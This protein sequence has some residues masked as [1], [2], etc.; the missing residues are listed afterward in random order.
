MG[1]DAKPDALWKCCGDDDVP[2]GVGMLLADQDKDRQRRNPG[3]P[4]VCGLH[5]DIPFFQQGGVQPRDDEV[6]KLRSSGKH[7]EE[8]TYLLV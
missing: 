6:S 2:P 7:C 5:A 3:G 4:R 1:I 8:C